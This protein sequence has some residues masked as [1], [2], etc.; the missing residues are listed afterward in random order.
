MCRSRSRPKLT[1]D[2]TYAI[3][4]LVKMA[5]ETP[6]WWEVYVDAGDCF[7]QPIEADYPIRS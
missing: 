5:Q 1:Y 4:M 3:W 6:A 7:A 2:L